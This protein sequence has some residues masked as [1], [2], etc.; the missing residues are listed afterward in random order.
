MTPPSGTLAKYSLWVQKHL[1]TG[2]FSNPKSLQEGFRIPPYLHMHNEGSWGWSSSLNVN[3][4]MLLTYTQHIYIAQRN[5]MQ[6]FSFCF[7]PIVCIWLSVE[8]SGF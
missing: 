5:L 1:G 2:Y 8:L 4:L 6:I 3:W 7:D